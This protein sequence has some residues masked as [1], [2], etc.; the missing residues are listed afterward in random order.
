MTELR[1]QNLVIFFM[2]LIDGEDASQRRSFPVICCAHCH[3]PIRD[4]SQGAV[5]TVQV[6]RDGEPIASPSPHH[7]IPVMVHDGCIPGFREVNDTDWCRWN[8][9]GSLIDALGQLVNGFAAE[10]K[11]QRAKAKPPKPE[12]IPMRRK[13]KRAKGRPGFAA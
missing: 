1:P 3:G 7:A 12:P 8:V 5:L 2:P 13:Q 10:E 11:R 6:L 9:W 4:A